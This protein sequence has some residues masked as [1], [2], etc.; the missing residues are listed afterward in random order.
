[1]KKYLTIDEYIS[2]FPQN[3]REILEKIRHKIKKSAPN[4]EEAI[5]Y[6]IPT[7]KLHGNLVHFG[8]YEKHVSFYPGPAAIDYFRGEL[9]EYQVSKGTIRFLLTAPIPYDLIAKITL[10]R[11]QENLRKAKDKAK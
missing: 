8:G 1:M 3:V 4:A 9:K 5:V 6:G 2:D 10:Y 11:V 7:F